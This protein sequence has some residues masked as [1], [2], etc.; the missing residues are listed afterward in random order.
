M[1]RT[2]LGANASAA[3]GALLA[4]EGDLAGAERELAAA[5]R[6]LRDDVP[7][8]HHT[9]LLAMLAR[10]R[11]RRGRLDQAQEALRSASEALIE[12]PDSGLL[13][14]LVG[15][16]EHELALERERAGADAAIETPSNA[17]LGVLRLLATDLS[18]REIGEQ[19]FVS[20]NTVRSHRRALYRKLG[21]HSRT[22]AVARGAA[23]NLLDQAGSPG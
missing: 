3:M 12:L 14:A 10:V 2:W 6:F 7:T 21:A 22:A 19:L 23:L 8:L 4:A 20:E 16:V 17:E 9:W 5:E 11:L 18:L 13:P 1:G 15:Q